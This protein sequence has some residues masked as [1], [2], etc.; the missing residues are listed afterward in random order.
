MV[1]AS[2][3]LASVMRLAARPVGRHIE[4]SNPDV[5]PDPSRGRDIVQARDRV[6]ATTTRRLCGGVWVWASLS[7]PRAYGKQQLL[8]LIG[9]LRERRVAALGEI[10]VH[11]VGEDI[12]DAAIFLE[13]NL[14]DEA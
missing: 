6:F 4:L 5:D 1:L 10:F 14:L 13:R 7:T 12:A 8:G 3:P 11:C 9:E 2:K